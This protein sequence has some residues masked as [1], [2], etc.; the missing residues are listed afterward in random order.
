MQSFCWNSHSCFVE[1]ENHECMKVVMEKIAKLYPTYLMNPAN[2][3]TFHPQNFCHLR[4]KVR[5]VY[6]TA[7]FTKLFMSI[8]VALSHAV[9]A[10]YEKLSPTPNNWI[11]VYE[12]LKWMHILLTSSYTLYEDGSWGLKSHFLFITNFPN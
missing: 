11:Y 4:Y 7:L 9:N 12:F 1:S 10:W 3:E 8:Q 5:A 2:H 6:F